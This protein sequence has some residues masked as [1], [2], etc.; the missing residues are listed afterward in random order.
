[1]E[2][3]AVFGLIAFILYI[4]FFYRIRP[5]DKGV[6]EYVEQNNAKYFFSAL[7]EQMRFR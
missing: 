7:Y 3:L 4:V 1:M 6:L 5:K 2:N